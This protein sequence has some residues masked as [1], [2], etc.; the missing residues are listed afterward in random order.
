MLEVRKNTFAR[1]HENVFF[2]EFSKHLFNAFKEKNIEGLLIGSPSCEVDERLQIDALL[3]TSNVVC[4]IDFKDYKGVV[5]LPDI[6]YFKNGHWTTEEGVLIKGGNSINPY[7]QLRFQKKRFVDVCNRYVCPEIINPNIFNPFHA[8][9]AICFHGEIKLNGEIPP[10]DKLNFFILDNLSFVEKI[11]DIVDVNDEEVVLDRN[12]FDVFKGVFLSD[13][14]KID[15]RPQEDKLRDFTDNSETLDYSLLYPDQTNALHEIKLFLE[16]PGQNI[17]ILQGTANSG[18]SFLIPYIQDLAFKIGIQEAELFAHSKRVANNLMSKIGVEKVNSIY[19][20]IYGGKTLETGSDYEDVFDDKDSQVIASVEK[21]LL[22]KSDNSENALFIVD[23]AQLISDSFY[24]SLDLIFGSGCLLKDFIG[25]TDFKNSK[26]KIIFIGDPCQLNIGNEN[27]S[28]L[29]PSYLESFYLLKTS[30]Y[31][32]LDNPDFS[33]INKQSLM[34]VEG[35]RNKSFNHL[36]F[37]EN[38]SFIFIKNLDDFKERVSE[39]IL[40][41]EGHLLYYSNYDSQKAN[42]WIKNEILNNG[43]DIAKNDLVLFNNNILIEDENDPNLIPR[44]IFNGQ[45]AT[46]VHSN[47]DLISE[48]IYDRKGNL[49]AKLNFREIYLKFKETESEA[50]VLSFENYR[51]SQKAELSKN[52]LLAY[53]IYLYKLAEEEVKKFETGE[54]KADDELIKLFNDAKSGKRVKSKINKKVQSLLLNIKSSSFY[55]FKNIALIRFG[56]A[57][58]VHKSMSYKWNNVIFNVDSEKGIGRTNQQYFKWI[59]TG[60]SRATNKIA[61]VNYKPISPFDKTEIIDS[62]R[63]V[64]QDDF[65]YIAESKEPSKRLLELKEFILSKLVGTE[66]IVDRIENLNWQ[67]R[68]YFKRSNDNALIPFIYNSQGKFRKPKLINDNNKL[69]G[70]I[71]QILCNANL[72]FNFD[73]L[74]PDWKRSVYESIAFILEKF[75]ISFVQVMQSNYKDKIKLASKKEELDIEIDYSGGGSFTRIT[76]KYYSNLSIWNEFNNVIKQLKK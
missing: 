66:I 53:N 61:L 32:L 31:Q 48:S 47:F 17:F 11:L 72:N 45:F 69:G 54:Y 71:L 19:S 22:K 60:I 23:E 40:N 16:D 18:K 39:M 7:G 74:R 9:R 37:N 76:A 68:Y 52:E 50:K 65:F 4:I 20:Y 49:V 28:S 5:N 75:G 42:L 33:D 10:S 34:C 6:N 64:K 55:K 43:D 13:P 58:T 67:E 57:M 56:W 36:R 35:I 1:S 46:V 12:S 38:N 27:E 21:V 24:K 51:T 30:A 44:R 62:S 26:R 41:N 15:N 3:I 14:F 70:E 25:F 73:C 63:G 59:Y 2:R 8:I 29:S